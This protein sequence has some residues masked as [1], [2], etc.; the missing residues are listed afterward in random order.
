MKIVW[1]EW[2]PASM[3]GGLGHGLEFRDVQREGY[4]GVVAFVDG[5]SWL[6]GDPAE[7]VV[8]CI[9][10]DAQTGARTLAAM[11]KKIAALLLAKAIPCG[12]VTTRIAG[13]ANA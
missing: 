9:K 11:K 6:H 5:F 8:L 7:V 3:P 13:I 4:G 10:P 1:Q 12:M 2:T